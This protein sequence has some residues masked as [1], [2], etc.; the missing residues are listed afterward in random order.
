MVSF[1]CTRTDKHKNQL[2]YHHLSLFFKQVGNQYVNL[3]RDGYGKVFIN[4]DDI[5]VIHKNEEINIYLCNTGLYKNKAERVNYII[6]KREINK[7]L[8]VEI[9]H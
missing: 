2:S 9:F 8:F 4:L 7:E 5:V 1:I 3:E 6:N